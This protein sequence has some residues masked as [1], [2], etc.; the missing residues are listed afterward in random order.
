VLDYR[1]SG[2][3]AMQGATGEGSTTLLIKYK[4]N[5]HTY[6][7]NIVNTITIII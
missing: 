4:A 5:T 1:K 7:H 6:T 2:N 3:D